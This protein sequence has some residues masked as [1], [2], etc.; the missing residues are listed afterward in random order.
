MSNKLTTNSSA[1]V[2][3]KQLDRFFRL[4]DVRL[5][6]AKHLAAGTCIASSNSPIPALTSWQ[7]I[8][9][10]RTADPAS[11]PCCTYSQTW[12]Q[13]NTCATLIKGHN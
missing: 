1:C 10:L 5:D 8:R 6:S 11:S 3:A 13:P 12:T 2:H 9:S 7:P 4:Q